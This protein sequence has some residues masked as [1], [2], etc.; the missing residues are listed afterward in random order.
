[1]IFKSGT[2]NCK[3]LEFPR[4]LY[5]EIFLFIAAS[6]QEAIETANIAFAP[7]FFFCSVPSKSI[8][9]LSIFNW[10]VQS[11]P[12]RALAIGPFIFSIALNTLFPR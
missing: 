7:S 5:N 2:G 10:S 11:M 6:L 3:I 4:Y 1:M 9:V 8:N 12:L